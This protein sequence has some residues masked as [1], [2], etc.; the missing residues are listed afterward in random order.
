MLQE[1]EAEAAR[2]PPPRRHGEDAE[3]LCYVLR[4]LHG[5]CTPS[6]AHAFTGSSG[7][8]AAAYDSFFASL[9]AI[10]IWLVGSVSVAKSLIYNETVM[11]MKQLCVPSSSHRPSVAGKSKAPQSS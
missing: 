10:P 9:W 8:A 11:I 7:Y 4:G 2:A 6:L 5:G 1:V 3:L